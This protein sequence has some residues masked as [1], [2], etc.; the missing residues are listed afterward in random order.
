MGRSGAVPADTSRRSAKEGR[1]CKGKGK[2]A[3]RG[4]GSKSLDKDGG[5]GKDKGK[6]K[7]SGKGKDGGKGAGKRAHVL[8]GPRKLRGR[9]EEARSGERVE[10]RGGGGGRAAAMELPAWEDF[11]P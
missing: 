11:A 8:T 2:D 3:D 5:K 1:G 9:E 4:K 7:D 10:E 6:D